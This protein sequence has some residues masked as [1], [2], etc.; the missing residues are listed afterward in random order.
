M[1]VTV[2]QYL[3]KHGESKKCEKCLMKNCFMII[4]LS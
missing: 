1:H 2:T 4:R 3:V